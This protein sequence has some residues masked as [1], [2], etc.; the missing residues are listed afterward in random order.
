[1]EKGDG[2]IKNNLISGVLYQVVLIVMGFVL[3]RL[4]LENFGSEING[5]LQTIKQIF[6]YMCLLEAGVGLATTQA[7]YK[8]VAEEY[9]NKSSAI[10][11][12]TNSYYIKTGI[13]YSAIVLLIAFIYS[14]AV[15]VNV[16]SGVLF[17]I[18]IL[19]AIPSL[20]SYFVCAKY[21]ILMEVDGR[22]YVITNSETAL[23]LLSNI[24][25][26][27]VLLLT[28]SL[29][30]IQFVYCVIAL[31]Q[32]A[33]LYFYAKRRYKWL[34]LNEKPDFKA[35]SQKNSVLLHQVSAMVFNNT[36]IILI[37]ILCDFK[38]VSVYTIYNIFFAQVQSF[39][40][41]IVSGFQFA[42][43]QMFQ[44]DKEKF[45]KVFVT[46]ETLYI[47]AT[48]IVYTLMAVFLL[49]LIGIY[50]GGINDADYI[51]GLLLLLFAVMNLLANIKLPLNHA[52]E[53]S[54]KFQETRSHAI[55]EMVIN[56]AVT[57]AAIIKWGIC[58]AILGTIAAL[59]YRCIVTIHFV[60]KKVLFR[61]VIKTYKLWFVNGVLFAAVMVV[62]FVDSFIGLSFTELFIKGLIYAPPI[63]IIYVAVNFVFC[64][65]A[66]LGLKGI[67][68]N[69]RS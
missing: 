29:V 26:I 15:K 54:G 43:G 59:L 46:Y 22:K 42:L 8:P 40:V 25:K 12:A 38:A 14:F 63:A 55:W 44:T 23:Q 13:T 36:D 20:F 45:N 27:L 50:T 33:Y 1:M 69:E 10:L 18:I 24:G 37:S 57:V 67:K 65:K 16:H 3:P 49:P 58:G 17:T 31:A 19:N 4:Y 34:N 56:I 39:I 61:S 6:T 11:A 48:F 51:N 64:P 60:N 5:V 47:M 62:F 28:D 2:R 21:R 41:S 66:F 7:L 32:M 53:F 9:K 35:I 68:K 52:L 30:L